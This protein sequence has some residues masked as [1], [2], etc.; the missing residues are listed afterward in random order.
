MEWWHFII[1]IIL[2][3]LVWATLI[4]N[5]LIRNKNLVAEGWSGIEVQLKRRA[6]LIPKLV[7]TVEGFMTHEKNVLQAI[8]D[9][10]KRC[11]EVN[12]PKERGKQEG[13]L[14]GAISN[15]FALAENYPDLKASQNFMQLQKSLSK[16]EDEIQL[17]RRYYNG[18]V[19][20]LN[21]LI[22]S[23]PSN[24]VARQFGFQLADYF[25]L[26][27]LSDRSSPEISIKT[28]SE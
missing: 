23:I 6:D 15:L 10:R 9:G 8:V 2:I 14:S 18:T 22:E 17:S 5:K 20:D 11:L 12:N 21:V 25:E 28:S 4:Y 24:L 26:E 27:D 7:D 13:Q 3:F 19:R 16:V 1:G